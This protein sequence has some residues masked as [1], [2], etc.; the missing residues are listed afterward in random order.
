MVVL[1]VSP[2]FS[3]FLLPV[4]CRNTEPDIIYP[5]MDSF[6]STQFDSYWSGA[7]IFKEKK[8]N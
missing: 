8:T 7:D 5:Q 6:N 2:G 4:I 1:L 3:H